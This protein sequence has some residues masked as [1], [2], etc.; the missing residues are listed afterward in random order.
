M[1]MRVLMSCESIET[2]PPRPCLLTNRNHI[3]MRQV[4]ALFLAIDGQR[5]AL[6]RQ[7]I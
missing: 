1:D 2:R 5:L 3:G 6:A 4:G 7:N